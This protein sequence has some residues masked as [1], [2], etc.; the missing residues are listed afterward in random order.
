ML[1]PIFSLFLIAHAVAHAGLAAGPIPRDP[2]PKSGAFFTEVTRSWLFQK[3][4]LDP[5]FVRPVGIILVALSTLGFL[6]SG[7]GGRSFHHLL[8]LPAQIHPEFCPFR[9][10][11]NQ[12]ELGDTNINKSNSNR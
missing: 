3:I 11:I 9:V 7:L 12:A 6:L 4:G 2:D 5:G 10:E 1:R 8:D